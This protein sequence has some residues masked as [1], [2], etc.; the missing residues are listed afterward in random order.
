M[1]DLYNMCS[2]TYSQDSDLPIGKS[3]ELVEFNMLDNLMFIYDGINDEH[4]VFKVKSRKL[5]SVLPE[6]EEM[7]HGGYFIRRSADDTFEIYY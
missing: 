1:Q 3:Y 4:F 7:I 5:L 6:D 2:F